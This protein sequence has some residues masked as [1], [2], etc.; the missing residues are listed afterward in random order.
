MHAAFLVWLAGRF[1]LTNQTLGCHALLEDK[2]SH[3]LQ[4][5][6]LFCDT[7]SSF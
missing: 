6:L 3:N 4:K 2:V 7:A 5:D 1:K